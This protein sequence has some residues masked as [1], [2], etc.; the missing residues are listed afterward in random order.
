[1]VDESSSMLACFS[2]CIANFSRRNNTN[3][4][5]TGVLSALELTGVRV[6]GILNSIANAL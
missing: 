4:M 2:V 6:T 5:E 1:M 3:Y